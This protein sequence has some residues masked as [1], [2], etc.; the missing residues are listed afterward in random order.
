L[1][2]THQ[3][4]NLTRM[5]RLAPVL[6]LISAV[7]L[8]S[9]ASAQESLQ[10]GK[11]LMRN[12]RYEA[13]LRILLPA[14][15]RAATGPY[16]FAIATCYNKLKDVP[17]A[18][19]FYRNALRHGGIARRDRRTATRQ[20]RRL[21]KRVNRMSSRVT[22]TIKSNVVGAL[23]TLDGRT[24]GRTPLSG[25]LIGP[26]R[27]VVI[28]RRK[29]Y[30]PWSK[31]FTVTAGQPVHLDATMVD[32]P[33][34][35]LVHTTPP[36]ARALVQGGPD[37]MTPCLLSLSSGEYQITITMAGY[38]TLLRSFVK[39]PGE[40]DELRLVLQAP[41]NEA[42]L[43]I[44]VNQPGARILVDGSRVGTS[45]MRGPF[46]VTPGFHTI[47]V[48]HKGFADWSKRVLVN[49]AQTFEI[50]A[51]LQPA[52]PVPINRPTR[53]TTKPPTVFRPVKPVEEPEAG[54][55][56][57]MRL[58]G[59]IAIGVGSALTAGGGALIGHALF[60][61][62]RLNTAQRMKIEDPNY[63]TNLF[64]LGITHADATNMAS[65]FKWEWPVGL[66]LAGVGLGA[67]A[68]GITLLV[69]APDDED[70]SENVTA[71]PSITV[72]PLFAP[73]VTGATA[74]LRF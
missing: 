16:A 17:P 40:F 27:H 13:A 24:V 31:G 55:G 4:L 62:N 21:K 68:T 73:G 34:G 29:G 46:A 1:P 54:N 51:R 39:R 47:T 56:A 70:S 61:R 53:T 14:Y 22:L 37:C 60:N 44:F 9:P 67:V 20:I 7:A 66:S 57:T 35:V 41:V 49:T 69:L 10:D 26:G 52:R 64:V 36:G 15:A 6:I 8:S 63:P 5:A 32:E 45:P 11:R 74:T 12:G 48:T 30:R 42:R 33:T 19:Q 18:L 58:W 65:L 2:G 25:L 28:I 72:S 38:Q 23:V 71:K 43:R 3:C 50:S 59:W